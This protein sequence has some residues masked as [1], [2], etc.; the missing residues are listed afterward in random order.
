MKD[1][2][3]SG[4]VKKAP[5]KTVAKATNPKTVVKPKPKNQTSK[6]VAK[7]KATVL[8]LKTGKNVVKGTKTA[9]KVESPKVD[10]PKLKKGDYFKF[11]SYYQKSGNKKT[12]IEWLVLKK[13]GA[14]MLLISRYGLDYKKYHNE[15]VKDIT[16]ENCDLRKWLNEEFLRN[17]FTESEKKKIMVTRLVNDSHPESGTIGGNS[18]AD[19][20]F[21]LSRAE[22]ESLFKDDEAR[23][24][25]LTQYAVEKKV[26]QDCSS[27]VD[28]KVTCYWWLR[29]PGYHRETA[30]D[31]CP[32]GFLSYNSVNN[33]S[34][35]VRPALWVE[36]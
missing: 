36:L 9:D 25:A 8:A 35:V 34:I 20:V 29:S 26:F 10:V 2:K 15:Y 16:W 22:V 1:T 33:G 24:C 17:A 28:G 4:S 23:K 32:F 19:R 6:T 31:V 27:L 21:C 13:S 30:S 11:G 5:A 14:K 18:T 3:S 7:D 12:P